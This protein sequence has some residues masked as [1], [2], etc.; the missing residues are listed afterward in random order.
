MEKSEKDLPDLSVVVPSVNSWSD[1]RGALEALY[2]QRGDLT[3][4]VLVVERVGE[5]VRAS[6]R[7][8]FPL[9]SS[10]QLQRT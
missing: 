6:L 7:Q 2:A 9:R 10:F 5:L 3:L 1:L 4:E 8:H